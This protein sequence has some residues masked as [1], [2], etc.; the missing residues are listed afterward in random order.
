MHLLLEEAEI[1]DSLYFKGNLSA[2]GLPRLRLFFLSCFG[3]LGWAFF[4]AGPG[5]V[6]AGYL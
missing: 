5:S 3:Q 4:M 2:K 6:A 1:V